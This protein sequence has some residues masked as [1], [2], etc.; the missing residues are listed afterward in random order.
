MKWDKIIKDIFI[1]KEIK[2]KIVFFQKITIFQG[3]TE[4]QVGKIL[5]VMYR[6]NYKAGEI[7]FNEQE[8]GKALFMVMSGEVE[9]VK[10]ISPTEE[11][12]VAK[13]GPGDFFGEMA[14]L[15]EKPRSAMVRVASDSEIYIIYKVNFD[16]LIEKN[17]QIGLK[18][19]KNLST[20]LCARLRGMVEKI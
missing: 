16:S 8:L 13:L 12:L 3:L 2:K 20:I 10:K 9:I 1:D 14:L 4:D 15:E 7:V 17:P 18:I 19:I 6:R 11:K 5:S